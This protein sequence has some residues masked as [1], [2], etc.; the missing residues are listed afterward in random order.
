MTG[1]TTCAKS[2]CNKYMAKGI[3][4]MVLDPINKGKDWCCTFGTDDPDDFIKTYWK[5]RNCA[6][7]FDEAAMT[8]GNTK[9]AQPFVETA[10]RGRH[11]GHANHYIA[12]RHTVINPSI[13][14]QCRWMYLFCV[15]K[16]DCKNL[17]E[18]WPGLKEIEEGYKLET[19]EFYLCERMKSAE[20]YNL[21]GA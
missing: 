21:F 10:L 1:K 8:C 20:R 6:V 15:V 3:A 18:E 12:Q 9:E 19:G 5:S 16:K 17:A 7:F 14:N 4:T 2:L 11:I 13:R